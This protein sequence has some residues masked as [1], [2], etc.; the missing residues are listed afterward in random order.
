M[1]SSRELRVERFEG[2]E[3]FLDRT[4]RFLVEREA[5]HNLIL[6]IATNLRLEPEFLAG[7]PNLFAVS[8]GG[9]VVAAAVHAPPYNLVLSEIDDPG[10]ISKLVDELPGE[11]TGALPGVNGPVEH[12]AAFAAA[13]SER[14]GRGHRL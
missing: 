9:R 6:G 3:P 13:W 8:A 2:V 1:A 10:A 11:L 7:P 5:E 12:A 14:T 4:E